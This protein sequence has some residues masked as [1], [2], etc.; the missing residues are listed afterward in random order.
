MKKDVPENLLFS[1][2]FLEVSTRLLDNLAIKSILPWLPI[3]KICSKMDIQNHI[4]VK[5]HIHNVI[6]TICLSLATEK[7]HRGMAHRGLPP[8]HISKT[9]ILPIGSIKGFQYL[10]I[11]LHTLV[12][13]DYLSFP[14]LQLYPKP[15]M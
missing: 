10:L 3:M 15:C 6:T 1:E 4:A 5:V 12:P 13:Y 2:S 9:G 11:L 7:K 8:N 14:V